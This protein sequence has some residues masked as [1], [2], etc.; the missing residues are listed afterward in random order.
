[1]SY[2][3]NDCHHAEQVNIAAKLLADLNIRIEEMSDY[4]PESFTFVLLSTY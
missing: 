3:T 2:N 1:M 4:V